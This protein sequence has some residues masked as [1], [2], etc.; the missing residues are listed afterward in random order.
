MSQAHEIAERSAQ[1]RQRALAQLSV[2]PET[3]RKRVS[4]SNALAVLHQLASSPSTAGDA[5]SLLHELQV[6]QVELDLQQEELRSARYELETTL[7]RQTALF[8]RAPVGYMSI[9]AATVLCEINL[10]GSRLLGAARDELL[11]RPL[12]GL[13][14]AS[15]V[16]ALQDLLAR[17]RDGLPPETCELRLLPHAGLTRVV[18]AAVD[19]DTAPGCFLVVLLAAASRV[20]SA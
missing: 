12:S 16:V 13:L 11:G 3:D 4:A 5:M 19:T 8:E 2:G 14:W 20:E 18:H 1:L 15:S 7:V 6:H 17:A 9:D 10:A